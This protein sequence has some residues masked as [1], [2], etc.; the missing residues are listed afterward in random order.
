MWRRG[1]ATDSVESMPRGTGYRAFVTLESVLRLVSGDSVRDV[2]ADLDGEGGGLGSLLDF[3]DGGGSV[4]TGEVFK[5]TEIQTVMQKISDLY[6][7]R[8]YAFASVVPLTSTRPEDGVVD[9]TFDI[10]KGDRFNVGQIHIT[11]N[12]PTWDKV[13]RREIPPARGGGLDGLQLTEARARLTRLGFFED[14]R[15]STPRSATP[16]TLDVNVEV[17][18]QPTGSFS[19]GAGFSS[20]EN[21]WFLQATSPRT[22]S[23]VSA[24]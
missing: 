8:G 13:V 24:M 4:Q 16:Q 6:S 22:T 15:I 11:G 17:V 10:S 20:V 2:L 3:R 18:E 21:F 12:D 14:V 9:L 5:L 1:P 7:A 19:I 23:W